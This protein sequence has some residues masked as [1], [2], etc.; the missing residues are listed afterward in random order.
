MKITVKKG[1]L[2]DS[3]TDAIVMLLFEDKGK[4][5]G[6]AGDVDAACNGLIGTALSDGVFKGKLY[7]TATVT[8]GGLIAPGVVIL[9]G[10]GKKTGFDG[11]KLRG[12]FSTAAQKMRELNMKTFAASLDGGYDDLSL[13]IIA[14]SAV[15][16]VLLG[17][18]Q[19]IPFKTI[20]R[21]EMKTVDEFVIM[22]KAAPAVKKIR[23]AAQAG[24][25]IALAACLARDLVATPSNEMTPTILARRAKDAARK[26]NIKVAI[27]NEGTMKKLGMNALLGVSRGSH[28]PPK[29]ITMEYRG[30]AASE[31]PIVLVGKGI[32]FDS[33]GISIKPSAGMED[34]KGDMAGGAAVIGA[35]A[36]VADLGLP[37]NV[38][39][40]IPATENLPGGSASKPGDVLKSMSGK[41]VEV[42]NTDAEGRLILIDAFTYAERYKPKAMIDLATLTGACVIALG[43]LIIG[44][45]GNDEDLKS[46]I[47][48][49]AEATGEKVWELPL[50]EEYDDLIRSDVADYKNTGG[51]PAGALT[52]GIFLSKFVGD[53]PWVHLDIAGPALLS[54]ARPYIPKGATGIGVRL[55]VEL[56]VNWA[57]EK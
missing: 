53:F 17:L 27:L 10:L 35:I 19:F 11:D 2:C 24:E 46:R 41:T 15:E 26:R 22:D 6:A 9:V 57:K 45:M 12:G 20:D 43:D 16:G 52:A 31:R 14:R 42:I 40:V 7:E 49:A 29:L 1:E 37:I 18:Y 13:E 32:T 50:P 47:R 55:M 23:T 33:G 51:R 4:L 21:D 44:M 34:M 30:A 36:A 48:R 38:V 54:K 25:K 5:K 28:E 39:G 8:T 3:T 56:L